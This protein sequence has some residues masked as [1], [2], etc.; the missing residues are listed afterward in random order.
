MKEVVIKKYGIKDL[1]EAQ[2]IDVEK[3]LN[4]FSL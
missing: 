4:V 2:K 1:K 3:Y